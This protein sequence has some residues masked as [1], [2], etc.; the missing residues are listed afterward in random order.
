[1]ETTLD[2]LLLDTVDGLEPLYPPSLQ[3]TA[4]GI[5][6]RLDQLA[7]EVDGI[8]PTRSDEKRRGRRKALSRNVVI[9]FDRCDKLTVL[10]EK[11]AASQQQ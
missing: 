10:M 6:I 3:N 5:S 8:K 2:A 1:M 4:G 11:A 9:E 7:A